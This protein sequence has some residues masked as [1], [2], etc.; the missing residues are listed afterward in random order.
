MVGVSFLPNIIGMSKILYGSVAGI[1]GTIFL[2]LASQ[3]LRQPDDSRAM[4]LFKYSIAYLFIL[5]LALICDKAI[6]G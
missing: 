4:R 1:S 2:L 3:L 5:F 6:L